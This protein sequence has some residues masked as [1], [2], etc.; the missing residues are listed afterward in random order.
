MILTNGPHYFWDNNVFETGF[1]DFHLMIVTEFKIGFQKMQL[2]AMSYCDYKHFDNKF[3]SD[4]QRC[5]SE[6]NLKCF[7]EIIF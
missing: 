5:T 7:K 3:R 6:D 2:C 4:I 1:F